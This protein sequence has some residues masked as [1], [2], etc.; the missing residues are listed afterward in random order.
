MAQDTPFTPSDM[1]LNAET[2]DFATI[3]QEV[4]DYY[5]TRE[6]GRGTGYKQ[7]K[8]WEYKMER[9]LDENGKIFNW[10]NQV[11][12]EYHRYEHFAAS[13]ES[14]ATTGYWNQ[15]GP[16]DYTRVGG[17]HNGGI[18]R[19]NCVAFHPSSANTLWAGTPAGGLWKTTN[20]GST[21]TPLTDGL[22]SIGVSGIAINPSNT[23]IIYILTGDGDGGD[24][25]SIGVLKSIN[26][27]D[28]WLSTGLSWEVQ[29]GVRGY[30]LLMHPSN[31]NI[32]FAA[33]STGVFKTTNGGASW[34]ETH[35][36]WTYD[37]EFK[38]GDPSIIYMHTGSAFARSIN[39]GDSWTTITSGLPTGESRGA[40]GVSA[41]NDAYVYILTGPSTG[42]GSFKGVFRSF[43]SGVTF[44]AK[45]TTPN[46][47][48]YEIDGQDDSNQTTYDLAMA[49]SPTDVADIF[50]AGIN[51]WRSTSYG[52]AGTM[53][54]VTQWRDDLPSTVSYCHADIHNVDFSPVDGSFYVCSDGGLYRSTNE[55]TS[56]T[57][58]SSGMCIMQFYDIADYE[59]DSNHLIGGTQDN[60]CN[61][62]N[63]YTTTWNHIEGA[64]G[65]DAMIDH[66]TPSTLYLTMNSSLHKSTNSG[67]SVT[68]IS[69]ATT[70]WAN[71]DMSSS[72]SSII[73][74]GYSEIYRS[75][76]G[77]SSWTNITSAST[78]SGT[79]KIKLGRNNTNRMY[80]ASSSGIW[81]TNTALSSPAT[82]TSV[83]AGLSGSI[84]DIAINPTNS[85]DVAVCMSGFSDGNKVFISSNGGSSWTNIT[86]T[87]PNIPFNCIEWAPGTNDALYVGGDV[88]IYY[89]DTDIGNWI[90]FRNGLP[91][92][93][94]YDLEINEAS[95]LLRAATHGR[96]IWE[97]SIYSVCPSFYQLTDGNLPGPGSMGYRYY[98]SS[99]SILS[100]RSID[101]GL[102]TDVNYQA[103]SL[104]QLKTGFEVVA[105]SK[106][107]GK[108][109]PCSTLPVEYMAGQ[110]LTGTYA[111]PM[112]G[113]VEE[114][115][116]IEG[117]AIEDDY[118][119]IYPN[120]TAGITNIEFK[121][122]EA[123][124]VTLSIMDI[125][126]R[127]LIS[128]VRE[129]E[130]QAGSYKM[131]QDLGQLASGFYMCRIMRGET[132]STA[133]IA[134]TD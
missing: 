119:L 120:P 29:D 55:G 103:G 90:P 124:S 133:R 109:A 16:T 33:T 52:N 11:F 116:G 86:G 20:L 122:E 44:G 79:R 21:W 60:G 40:I 48:G 123:T 43:D 51:L 23:D 94:V 27:G 7:W 69:P 92:T 6:Q 32:L 68:S 64:D 98:Q 4:E 12:D 58:L 65:S 70:G 46:V 54:N 126:G 59:G 108:I 81:M 76:N 41:D 25:K 14:R 30:K 125:S 57:K 134:V 110:D 97:T 53:T 26:G 9:R 18:G 77:G 112:P 117:A 38:P 130:L 129:K 1:W 104:I 88:G 105:G 13:D 19:V 42:T 75:N 63:T 107:E 67:A 82:W 99:D 35:T 22:P 78:A 127:E 85:L 106:F 62:K 93:P 37:M 47:L 5:A 87:L 3:Q 121:L 45:A 36:S 24:T 15:V 114:V 96:G 132:I 102:G 91:H 39:T 80:A 50:T 71:L 8:R 118:F 10:V 84:T 74:A 72:N 73:Y 100:T 131:A 61:Y 28:T 89:R 83:S 2:N 56:F 49:V 34:T 113:V 111:G 115:V 95:N 31:S 17:G 101:G 128:M 66:T